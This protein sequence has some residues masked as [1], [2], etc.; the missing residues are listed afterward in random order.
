MS[1]LDERADS[2]ERKLHEIG[3]VIEGYKRERRE[4]NMKLIAIAVR[5]QEFKK[6]VLEDEEFEK[7]EAMLD[8]TLLEFRS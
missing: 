1:N 4:L 5:L 2:I 7:I 3:L 6:L 8:R